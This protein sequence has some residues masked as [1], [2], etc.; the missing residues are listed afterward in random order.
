[1]FVSIDNRDYTR[2][3]YL[4]FRCNN[5]YFGEQCESNYDDIIKNQTSNLN[6]MMRKENEYYFFF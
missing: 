2:I 1:M 6:S 4:M 3:F 5:R